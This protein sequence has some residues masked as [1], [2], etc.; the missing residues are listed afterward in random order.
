MSYV[1][2]DALDKCN[3]LSD[4]SLAESKPPISQKQTEFSLKQFAKRKGHPNFSTFNKWMNVYVV[5]FLE[6]KHQSIIRM[7]NS[8]KQVRD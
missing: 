4:F 5:G 6:K 2:Y 8:L 7:Q 3:D 1:K